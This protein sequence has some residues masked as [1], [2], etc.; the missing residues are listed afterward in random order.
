MCISRLLFPQRML[1]THL[2]LREG[3]SSNVKSQD[4]ESYDQSNDMPTTLDILRL[5]VLSLQIIK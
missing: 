3:T 2:Q 5:N 1:L 4:Y